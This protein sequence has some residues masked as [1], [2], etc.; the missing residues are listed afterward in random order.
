MQRPLRDVA[1]LLVAALVIILSWNV[2]TFFNAFNLHGC[3]FLIN[4]M[5]CFIFEIYFLMNKETNFVENKHTTRTFLISWND[6][7]SEIDF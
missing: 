4:S 6:V 3:Y 2:M 1:F 7:E 5:V